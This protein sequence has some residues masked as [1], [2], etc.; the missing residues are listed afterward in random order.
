MN[1]SLAHASSDSV[2]FAAAAPHDDRSAITTS[3]TVEDVLR[4]FP[5]ATQ[6]FDTLR[7]DTCCGGMATLEA[8]ARSVHLA[9][10]DLLSAIH[11]VIDEQHASPTAPELR[12]NR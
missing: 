10:E 6:L 3:C 9:P 2:G 8:A 5:A 1:S 12:S 7:I 11:R 4:R